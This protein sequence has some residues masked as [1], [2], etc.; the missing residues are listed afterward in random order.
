MG[1]VTVLLNLALVGLGILYYAIPIYTPLW[2]VHGVLLMFTFTWNMA[3]VLAIKG[4]TNKQHRTGK[5]LSEFSY[6]Y[7]VLFAVLVFLSM[8]GN[9]MLSASLPGNGEDYFFAWSLVLAGYFGIAGLGCLLGML[10]VDHAAHATSTAP[11]TVTSGSRVTLASKLRRFNYILMKG[12]AYILLCT[13][14]VI[15]F[16]IFAP[17]TSFDALLFGVFVSQL[18]GFVGFLYLALTA[19]LLRTKDRRKN[20][21]SFPVVAVFGL[22]ISGACF[23]PL[24]STPFMVTSAGVEFSAAF[25]ADWPSR[26]DP[27]DSAHFMQTPFSL[28]EYYLN[29]A[30]TGYQLRR[31]VLF[32]TSTSG[33]DS[34]VSLY[35]DAYLPP[36]GAIGL[37]GRNS[38]LVRI[39]GGGWQIGD[40]ARGNMVTMNKYFAAQGYAVFD[41][42][43]G[44]RS[45]GWEMPMITP[46]NVLAPNIT[47]DDMIR[48]VGFFFKYI[49]ANQSVYQCNLSS[50]FISGG[51]AGGQLVCAAGQAINLG[52]YTGMFGTGVVIRGIIPFYPANGLAPPPIKGSMTELW[53][54]TGLVGPTSP[55]CLIFQGTTDLVHIQNASVRFKAEYAIHGRPCALIWAPL[56]GHGNDIHFSGHYS[57]VFLYYMERFMVLYR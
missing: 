52:N 18:A 51:S 14:P 25:G 33:N 22:A 49:E 31:N 48:H 17:A 20:K 35:F 2:D 41:I 39:H 46:V 30:I 34:G 19:I 47:T 37:P 44:M 5:N 13:G 6:T 15:V 4:M 32:Y 50:T 3:V 7:L 54:P 8:F 40:K 45:G 57:R 28:G 42:Q 29:H 10:V 26:I 11:G 53:D 16:F 1:Q 21:V 27:A 24:M 23:I 56:A 38:T 9:F 55:P 43:Y 36:A 12:T